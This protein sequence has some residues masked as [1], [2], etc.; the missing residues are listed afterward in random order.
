[1]HLMPKIVSRA[2]VHVAIVRLMPKACS[3]PRPLDWRTRKYILPVCV[4][5][6]TKGVINF[7]RN[8]VSYDNHNLA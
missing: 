7:T 4:C 6:T 3:A 8:T 5:F 1:M 2:R